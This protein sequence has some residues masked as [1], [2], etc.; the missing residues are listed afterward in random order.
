LKYTKRNKARLIAD[1][2]KLKVQM[3]MGTLHVSYRFEKKDGYSLA[4]SCMYFWGWKSKLTFYDAFFEED[5][6]LQRF[7]MIHEFVHVAM[8]PF[9]S[10]VE[11]VIDG[12]KK[13]PMQQ[14]YR[15]NVKTAREIVVDRIAGAFKELL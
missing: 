2:E 6:G 15:T 13:G 14:V 3:G 11:K 5:E 10:T 7:T 1:C 8:I 12:H 9:D 4:D